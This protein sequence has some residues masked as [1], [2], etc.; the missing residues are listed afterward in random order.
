MTTV[1]IGSGNVAWHMAKAFKEA[2]IDLIQLYGRNEKDL[3][4]LSS[5]INVEY[6]TD[7]LKQADFYLICTS[8]KAIAEVSKQIPYEQALVAHTSGSLSRDVLEGPYRKASFYPLQ[9]FSKSRKL[10]YSKIPLFVDAGWESDNI[11]LTDLANKI[12]TNVMRINHEQRKQMHLSA[13]FACNFVNHLYAQAEVIC[14]QNE[15]PF[16]YLLP[17]IEETADKIKTISPKDA[18]TGP[19]AR[20]DQNVIR[21]QENLID[22]DNQLNIYKMLTES[23]I[24]MYEL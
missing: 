6:S 2:G 22:N 4:K 21:F 19:A 17:L 18:Q 1:I 8:D 15:I 12:S 3:K 5:E 24:K 9:T 13:V 14:K 16:N 10:D 7:K 23:I 11:L 20:N